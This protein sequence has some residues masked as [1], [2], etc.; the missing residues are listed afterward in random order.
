MYPSK[1]MSWSPSVGSV[2]AAPARRLAAL[3][4]H[5]ASLGLAAL[6]ARLVAAPARPRAEPC[7]EFHAEAGAPE[8]AL[9]VDGELVGWLIGVRRL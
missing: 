1:Q 9:Y 8:G 2:P 5:G 3:L 7:I 6:A 4:L